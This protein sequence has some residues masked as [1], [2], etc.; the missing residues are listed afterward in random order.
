MIEGCDNTRH[1]TLL[2]VDRHEVE[3]QTESSCC[4]AVKG[5][6]EVKDKRSCLVRLSQ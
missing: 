3:E 2:Y 4:A 5:L 6:P 1:H